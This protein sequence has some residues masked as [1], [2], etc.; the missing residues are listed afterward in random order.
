[1]GDDDYDE[2]VFMKMKHFIYY[3]QNEGLKDDSP[4]YIFDSGFDR[5]RVSKS[6]KKK[7]SKSSIDTKSLLKDYN[8]PRYFREDLFRL[9]GNRRPPYKWLV[10]GGA[11]SGTG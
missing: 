4:L 9:T 8:A 3:A 6:R 10:M 5:N 1:M 11:R 2:S 7:D